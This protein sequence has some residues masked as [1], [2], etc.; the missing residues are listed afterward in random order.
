V[1][2]SVTLFQG[3]FYT[4]MIEYLNTGQKLGNKEDQRKQDECTE[5]RMLR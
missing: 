5:S 2:W 4:M 3:N 1:L